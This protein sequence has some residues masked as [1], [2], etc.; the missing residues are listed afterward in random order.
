MYKFHF[1]L[2][3]SKMMYLYYLIIFA[4]LAGLIFG[5][6]KISGYSLIQSHDPAEQHLPI[7]ENYRQLL[8]NFITH[9]FQ[10]LKMWS[11]NLGIGADQFQTFAYY[12]IGDVFAYIT[13]LFPSSAVVTVYQFTLVLRLFCVGLSF[14]FFARHFK[15]STSAILTGT[16]IYQFT[17]FSLYSSVMQPFFLTPFIIFPLLIIGI[18]KIL[19]GAR[20]HFFILVLTW[21]FISNFYFSVVLGIGALLY[22]IL[23]YVIYYRK[24]LTFFKTAAIFLFSAITSLLVSSIMLLPAMISV[25]DSTRSGGLFANGLKVFPIY[26]YI[27]LPAQLIASGQSTFWTKF[28]FSSFAVLAIIHI[29]YNRKKY[30]L[31]ITTFIMGLIMLLFPLFGALFNGFQAPSNRWILLLFVPVALSSSLFIDSL[32]KMDLAELKFMG[33][34]LVGYLILVTVPFY[35]NGET[36]I[37]IPI[38]FLISFF[39]IILLYRQRRYSG[40]ILLSLVLLNL[41]ATGISYASPFTNTFSHTLMPSDGYQ[42]LSKNIFADL[43]KDIPKSNAFRVSTISRN[44]NFGADFMLRNNLNPDVNLINSYYSIQNGSLSTFSN[45]LQNSQY[46]NNVPLENFDDRTIANNFLGVK[47]LFTKSGELNDTKIP[48]GYHL[49][50]SNL[51]K[52]K[53]EQTNLYETQNNF[54][55]IYWQPNVISDARYTKLSASN[56]ERQLSKVVSIADTSDFKQNEPVSDVKNVSFTVEKTTNTGQLNEST[57][58]VIGNEYHNNPVLDTYHIKIKDAK[59]YQNSELHVSLT[60]IKHE[61]LSVKDQMKLAVLNNKIGSDKQLLDTNASLASQKSLSKQ[62]TTGSSG[63]SYSIGLKSKKTTNKIK[64]LGVD[65]LSFFKILS[66]TT[67]NMGYQKKMPESLELL[68]SNSGTYSFKIKVTAVPLG[69]TYMNEVKT[70]QKNKLHSLK[71]ST[72]KVGGSMTTKEP[73]ILTS[74]IPYSEGWTATDNGHTVPVIKT[75]EAF[76]GLKLQKGTHHIVYSYKTPGLTTG[77][78]LSVLG[79]LIWFVSILVPIAWARF[80]NH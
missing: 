69:K 29:I 48:Y 80:K 59:K 43:D 49:S 76:I 54:P 60:N 44:Y 40:R 39:A 63:T 73:G 61:A 9:P 71:F 72:N 11:W 42:S 25:L 5:T 10:P 20:P 47:Y 13:L 65:N 46:N 67:L 28:G 50:R 56:K 78:V 55:L 79:L 51:S 77:A 31:L 75:N 2:K 34:C 12:V 68:L 30:P 22:L 38:I 53:T 1:D 66:D 32:K 37:F 41:A 6:Y 21:T 19:Q 26:Y 57:I 8:G 36:E 52:D 23:R 3:K 70:I 74:S 33:K 35:I 58:P 45:N 62:L 64:Q 17:S 16:F 4:I 18:E 24:R 27:N 15:L 7:L 14:I